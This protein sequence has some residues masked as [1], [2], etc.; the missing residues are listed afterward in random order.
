G[1]M[2]AKKKEIKEVTPSADVVGRPSHQRIEKI[3]LP[4]K[5]KQTQLLG[6]NDAKAGAAEL[7]QKLHTEARIF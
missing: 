7:A 6:N 1:I 5:M 4:Q 3:Y 2:A